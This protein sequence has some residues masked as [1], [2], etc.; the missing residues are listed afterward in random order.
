M[1]FMRYADAQV[2]QPHVSQRGWTKV[3]KTASQPSRDLVSQA[4]EILGEAFTPDRY[5]LTHCTIVAS[6][7]VDPVPNVKLGRVKVGKHGKT[8]NRKYADYYIRP[9][10]SQFVN[11]NGDS[12]SRDVLLASYRTFIGGH[13]FLEHVQ[14]EEQSKGRIIDAVAR[15]IGDSVYIDIL[16]ATDR[17]HTQLVS[18]IE[19]GKIATLSMGCSVEETICSQCGNCAVDETE[20]CDHIKYAK[21]NKFFDE[22]GQ[23]RIVAELCGHPTL[24]NNGGVHFIE[25]SWVAV[26][27]FTGA[28]MR[29]I[30]E[31]T[32]MPEGMA[33]RVQAVL[34]TP[35]PQWTH[36]VDPRKVRAASYATADLVREQDAEV[37]GT[38]GRMSQ[39]DIGDEGGDSGAGEATKGKPDADKSKLDDASDDLYNDLV[40]R[41]VKKVKEDLR[42]KDTE[43]ALSAEDSTAWQNDSLNRE[44]RSTQYQK[45]VFKLAKS[46]SSDADFINR[47]AALDQNFGIKLPVD[48]YRGCLKVGAYSNYRSMS[49]FFLA[50]REALGR[51]TTPAELRVM[52]RVGKLLTRLGSTNPAH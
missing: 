22:Q 52:L 38:L 3:R 12:W 2:V 8:I 11:N 35:P 5:L 21:R 43:D 18:D 36:D 45:S 10:C 24:P 13:N 40:E 37:V 9:Q 44:A 14:I 32:S 34:D 16:V 7:D 31:P 42:K 20:L 33:R 46:A 50:C 15:D 23:Q 19:S 27:A 49:R 26:P 39:W 1:A 25:A 48:L 6:V 51:P 41:A 17:R 28:V 29:N 4:S 47:L 30:L